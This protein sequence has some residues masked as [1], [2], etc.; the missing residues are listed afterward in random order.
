M[1][2]DLAQECGPQG[3]GYGHRRSE[4]GRA[5]PGCA[6]DGRTCGRHGRVALAWSAQHDHPR[7]R[8]GGRRRGLDNALQAIWA[9]VLPVAGRTLNR[10][11]STSELIVTD[12]TGIRCR[13]W[14]DGRLALL[15]DAAHAMAPTVGHGAN[16]VMV[17]AA[18]LAAELA[19]DRGTSV[20]D[21]LA[22]CNDVLQGRWFEF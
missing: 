17:D 6:Y 3:I 11:A 21:A 5:P 19:V 15:G 14:I 13:S 18:V 7:S 10:V 8:G 16:S 12:V 22:R 4:G 1:A 20:P 2:S 9:D